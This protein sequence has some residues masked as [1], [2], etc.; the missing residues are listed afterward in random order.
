MAAGQLRSNIRFSSPIVPFCWTSQGSGGLF[1]I[2][3]YFRDKEEIQPSASHIR[4]LITDLTRVGGIDHIDVIAQSMGAVGIVDAVDL[5]YNSNDKSILNRIRNII[6]ASSD[7][8]QGTV[9]RKY[10]PVVNS[11]ENI[12]TTIYACKND[13]AL[14]FS[15]RDLLNGHP[16]LGS[17]KKIYIRPRMVTIDISRVNRS[18]LGHSALFQTRAIANDLHY[19]LVDS[20][21]PGE[22]GLKSTYAENGDNYWT[23]LG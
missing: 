23:M 20:K 17:T 19:L 4:T 1:G 9:D 16:R 14:N 12:K 11:F 15:G 18:E 10:K 5:L 7:I 2:F 8:D 13:I 21:L 22:R 6:F 3:W